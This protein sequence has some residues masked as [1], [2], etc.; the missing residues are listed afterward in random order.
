MLH[1]GKRREEYNTLRGRGKSYDPYMEILKAIVQGCIYD[2]ENDT[3]YK[4]QA[5]RFL[6]YTL[7]DFTN[8]TGH[9]IRVIMKQ[10]GLIK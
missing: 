9:T 1:N 10:R 6:L 2:I 8:C 4:G 3:I 7:P 5:V